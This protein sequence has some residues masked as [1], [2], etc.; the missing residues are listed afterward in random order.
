MK[1][2]LRSLVL[3]ILIASLQAQNNLPKYSVLKTEYGDAYLASLNQLADQ[4]YRVLAVGKYTIL[5]LEAT[6]PDTYR[7]VRLERKNGPA[8]FTNWLNEQGARGY[9][10]LSLTGLLEKAPHPRNYEYRTSRHGALGPSKG[11]ELSSMVEDGY[12]P[13]RPVFFSQ[14]GMHTQEMYFEREVRQL[15]GAAPQASSA[16]VEVADAMRA[17]HVMKR[18]DELAQQGYRFLGPYQSKKGGGMAVMMGKCLED[19][20]GR[21][22]YRH[23]DAKDAVQV[24][25]DLNALGKDGFRVLPAALGERP[26]LLERDTHEKLTFSYRAL[27]PSDAANLQ[28]SL[29]SADQEGYTLLNFVWHTGWSARGF[30]VIEKAATASPTP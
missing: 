3:L 19:C 12:R 16:T 28:Q 21:Y 27:E 5:R 22:Q 18:V 7:Y 29:S 2:L 15:A 8:Q 14:Y 30:L 17:D 4:G 9:R 10:W 23:F 25:R 26:H 1:S 6:P 13:G 11:S 24:E 20:A